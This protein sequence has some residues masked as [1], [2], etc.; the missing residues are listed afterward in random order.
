VHHTD[1]GHGSGWLTGR[2]SGITTLQASWLQRPGALTAGLRQLGTVD[3]SVLSEHE[4]TLGEDEAWM[5]ERPL[6]QAIWVREIIMHV[7]T[8]AAVVARSLTPLT[9]SSQ[10]WAGMRG[11][12]TRPLADLLYHDP[13]IRRSAFRTARL[14]PSQPL[15]QTV[16]TAW[17]H[18]L[19][20]G[21]PLLARCSTFW[22]AGQPLLVEECFLPE[23]WSLAT[24][25]S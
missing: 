7:D 4:A 8:T 20:S 13:A 18:A 25:T 2:V 10:E 1:S 12:A 14:R 23:F 9:A 16:E 5:L 22:R 3:L 19:A 17:P 24:L 6:Q 15:F 21:A 11:L